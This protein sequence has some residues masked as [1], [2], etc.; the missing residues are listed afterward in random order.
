MKE[1]RTSSK[2]FAAVGR[3]GLIVRLIGEQSPLRPLGVHP[4]SSA[5]AISHSA[6][7]RPTASAS[8]GSSPCVVCVS[9]EMSW[10]GRM[11]G[12]C[13]GSQFRRLREHSPFALS[14]AVTVVTNS[15]LKASVPGVA[16]RP[17]RAKA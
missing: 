1:E 3:F 15:S 10:G 7:I 4:E 5:A 11:L 17:A 16:A 6:C 12:P 2:S 14:A 13:S 9:C 8:N